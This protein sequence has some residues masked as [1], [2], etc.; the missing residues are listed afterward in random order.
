M[1]M[2]ETTAPA[3]VSVDVTVDA[4]IEHAFA[5]FTEG[6]HT[7]WDPNHHLLDAPIETMT[8][9]PRVGGQSRPH[10]PQPGPPRHRLGGHGRR[11]G[12]GLGP[13]P[14]RRGGGRR[15]MGR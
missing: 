15:L 2:T 9:E 1:S 13:Q 6:I 11:R 10:A 7:W 8:F 5:V 14:V 12:A 3:S 4:P